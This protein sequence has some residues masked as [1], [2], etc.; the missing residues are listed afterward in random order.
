MKIYIKKTFFLDYAALQ[1]TQKK[2]TKA[3]KAAP[4][5]ESGA[6]EVETVKP[7]KVSRDTMLHSVSKLCNEDSSII[8]TC[9]RLLEMCDLKRND[10]GDTEKVHKV[11]V[12][13]L[14][15]GRDEMLKL[16]EYERKLD[17]VKCVELVQ[18]WSTEI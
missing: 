6:P 4:V 8:D 18:K 13:S 9:R 17:V 11:D 3:E 16:L 2:T 10:H 5:P 12:L 15:Q 14:F 1:K 7:K